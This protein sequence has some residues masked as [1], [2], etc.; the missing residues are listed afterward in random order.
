MAIA[1]ISRALRMRGQFRSNCAA[2]SALQTTAAMSTINSTRSA[3]IGGEILMAILSHSQILVGIALSGA[4]CQSVATESLGGSSMHR[5][6]CAPFLVA[7][8]SLTWAAQ[9]PQE[10]L[11]KPPAGARHYTIS[12]TAGK[13]GDI[14]SWKLSDGRV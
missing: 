2:R 6:L 14:W 7:V 1:A 11:S 8:G 13:H 5:L 10:Q 4:A 12:S 3:L 9:A